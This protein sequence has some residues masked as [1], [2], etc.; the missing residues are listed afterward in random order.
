MTDRVAVRLIDR[1]GVVAIVR[2]DPEA[3]SCLRT[4]L[5]GLDNLFWLD[6]MD[7]AAG[8]V[9]VCPRNEHFIAPVEVGRLQR[10]VSRYRTIGNP[11][12]VRLPIS[13]PSWMRAF[14]GWIARQK[15]LPRG[16]SG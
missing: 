1:H 8:L 2:L 7:P 14:P 11:Q 15:K 5:H 16:A 9:I 10:A 12:K 13:T 6:D 4:R 3:R